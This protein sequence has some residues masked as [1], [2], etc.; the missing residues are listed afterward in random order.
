MMVRGLY[1][2]LA[3]AYKSFANWL[4]C[5]EQYEMCG[6]TRQITHRSICEEDDPNN[7]LTEIQIPV[8]KI[9]K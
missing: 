3:K 6:Y 7:Y 1:S 4:S 2:N 5:H 8:R 9:S